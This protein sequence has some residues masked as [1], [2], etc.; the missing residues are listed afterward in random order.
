MIFTE[1]Q[2]LLKGRQQFD[3]MIA[4]AQQAADEH[5]RIDTLERSLMTQLLALGHSLLGVF[6]ARQGQGDQ[7]ETIPI[8]DGPDLKRLPQP[9]QRRYLSVFGEHSI[10]RFVY[11]TREGQKIQR[12]PL[13]ERLGLPQGDFSYLLQDWSQRLC[14]KGSFAEAAGSLEMLLGLSLGVRALEQINHAVAQ[15][16]PAFRDQVEPPP[17][18]EEGS[19]LVV[20]ADGKGVPMRRPVAR[21]D[22]QP[23]HRRTK[24]EKAN[25]KQMACVGAVYSIAPFVRDPRS[26]VDEVIRHQQAEQRPRPRHKKVW[27]EMSREVEGFPVTGKD[28]LFC[29]LW[30]ELARRNPSDERPVVCLMDGERALWEAKKV[31][32]PEAVGVLDLFHVMERLWCVSHCLH[33]EGSVEAGRF[34]AE[35]LLS[36][37]EGRVGSVI[38]GWRQRL[39]K[40]RFSSSRRR[41]IESAIEYF[42]NNRDHMKY[43]EYL[44][45]GYPIGSGVAEGACRHL[46]KDRM[47]QAGMRWTV[48]GAQAMLH[49]R[50]LYLNDEWEEYIAF[51]IEREQDRLYRPAAA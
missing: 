20:T 32:F 43:D 26:I 36:L 1:E 30:S 24:G 3:Q 6:L 19:I 51:H 44:A 7:G 17:A 10:T 27:A 8:Q 15:S 25:K 13:D 37:L 16:A 41:V 40:G 31:Y 14:L 35:G 47:E 12:V 5:R 29:R 42:E 22:P 2:A 38:G 28:G 46:V 18:A 4:L 39:T 9:H 48:A 11:G 50:G 21:T 33:K 49:V 23:H 45:A 34:V